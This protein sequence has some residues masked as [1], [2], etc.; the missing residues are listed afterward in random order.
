MKTLKKLKQSK[1]S[2]NESTWKIKARKA[3]KKMRARMAHKKMKAVTEQ[4][5]EDT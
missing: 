1:A 4:M 2:K 3:R 5:H